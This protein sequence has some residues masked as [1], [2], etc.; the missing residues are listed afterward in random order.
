MKGE[1]RISSIYHRA[2]GDA[3][4]GAEADRRNQEARKALWHSLG[5]VVI[6]PED[7][8]N[9]WERQQVINQANKLYGHRRKKG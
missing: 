3:P 1:A 5:V 4:Q 6:D 7:I 2:N 9:D 8:N